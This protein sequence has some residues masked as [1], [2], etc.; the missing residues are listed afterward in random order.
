MHRFIDRARL[1]WVICG[2]ILVV[3]PVSFAAGGLRGL[4]FGLIVGFLT[5]L[6]QDKISSKAYRQDLSQGSLRG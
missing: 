2:L 6:D 3:A 4:V 5:A 1:G